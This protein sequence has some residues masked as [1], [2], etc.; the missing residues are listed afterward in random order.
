MSFIQLSANVSGFLGSEL[1][2]LFRFWQWLMTRLLRLKSA[3]ISST[4]VLVVSIAV[5]GGMSLWFYATSGTI[6]NDDG[7]I[8]LVYSANLA[9]GHGLVYNPGFPPVEGFTNLLLVLL[10]AVFHLILPFDAVPQAVM[11]TCVVAGMIMLVIFHQVASRLFGA[12]RG[13]LATLLVAC[14]PALG[15]WAVSVLETLMVVLS[16]VW[17]LYHAEVPTGERQSRANLALLAAA[18]GF[19]LLV[20]ADG[21][22]IPMLL[23]VFFLKEMRQK[24]ALVTAGTLSL[25]GG[26]HFW[27]RHWYFGAWLPNTATC[28]VDGPISSRIMNGLSTIAG[29][30]AITGLWLPLLALAILLITEGVEAIKTKSWR[31][32]SF[33]TMYFVSW[34]GYF[35]FVG[36][37]VYGIRPLLPLFPL[38]VFALFKI[39][40]SVEVKDFGG[41][42]VT[43]M[44]LIICYLSSVGFYNQWTSIPKADGWM[45]LGRYLEENYPN[46][47]IALD[48]A[49]KIA[50]RYQSTSWKLDM[51]G[52]NDRYIA[53]LASINRP[54]GHNKFDMDYV[55]SQK[56]GLI[57]TWID[58]QMALPMFSITKEDYEN[59][60]YRLFLLVN[61]NTGNVRKVIDLDDV[62]IKSIIGFEQCTYAVLEAV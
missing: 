8:S 3:A 12:T 30:A 23:I 22:L 61:V 32:F 33:T 45:I 28:K 34:V 18:V 21:F 9:A 16:I 62:Q 40:R 25:V 49:G 44:I 10:G 60:N 38:G 11:A 2:D 36:G 42:V 54:I 4:G 47:S 14:C 39:T 58:Y 5:F 57:A 20:R 51:L 31:C 1:P 19:S 46:R 48:A 26:A 29:E 27:W 50:W 6:G 55:F 17:F 35:C 59:E 7:F 53:S 15:F 56:P 13:N 41:K 43:T 37:D 52:L 24:E